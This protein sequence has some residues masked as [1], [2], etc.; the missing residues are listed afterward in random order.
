MKWNFWGMNGEGGELAGDG[1][2]VR[3]WF[4]IGVSLHINRFFFLDK[5]VTKNQAG[6]K[7]KFFLL[8]IS[9]RRTG[10][11]KGSSGTGFNARF[12]KRAMAG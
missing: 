5:K 2:E 12:F 6:S 8:G 3:G 11:R 4:F 10:S 7:V 1:F 9:R